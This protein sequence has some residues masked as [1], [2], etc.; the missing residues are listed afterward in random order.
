MPTL[1]TNSL[2]I[3]SLAPRGVLAGHPADQLL[4]VRRNPRPAGLAFPMLEKSET[5][6]VPTD[7]SSGPYDGQAFRQSNQR[8]G[9]TSVERAGPV[10]PSRPD[11]AFPRLFAQEEILGGQGGFGPKTKDQK[12]KQIRKQ[13]QPARTEVHDAL[14]SFVF[15]LPCHFGGYLPRFKSGR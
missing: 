11:F 3:R 5:L 9:H 14:I 4:E 6:A 1:S 2:P 12:A 7:E 15:A 13:V 8:L 10:A